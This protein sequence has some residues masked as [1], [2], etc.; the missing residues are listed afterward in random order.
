MAWI[1]SGTISLTNG[2]AV[3]YGSG[4]TWASNG[5]TSPGDTLVIGAALYQVLSVQADTQLTLASN[6][7]GTTASGQSYAIINTGLLPSALAS[8]LAALQSKYLTTVSQLYTWE[9]QTSGTV[10]LTNPATG[11]T[12]YVTPLIA[13]MNGIPN[14][15][16]ANSSVTSGQPLPRWALP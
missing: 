11:V 2:S 14:A 13:F 4:T 6:Y 1:T 7:L 8:N 9:T 15:S 3:V 5:I 16:L 10:P 12:S